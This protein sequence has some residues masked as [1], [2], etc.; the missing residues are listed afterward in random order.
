MKT[1]KRFPVKPVD[2]RRPQTSQINSS[3]SRIQACR[4]PTLNAVVKGQ[5]VDPLAVL[6]VVAW[7]DG[8]DISELYSQVVSSH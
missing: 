3:R 7:V 4:P 1:S 8:G 6:D 5:D 2:A